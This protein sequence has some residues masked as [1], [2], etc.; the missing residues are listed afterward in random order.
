MNRDFY[1]QLTQEELRSPAS[2][3]WSQLRVRF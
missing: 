1:V 3:H 2:D